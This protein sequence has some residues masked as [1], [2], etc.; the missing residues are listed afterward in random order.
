MTKIPSLKLQGHTT[1]DRCWK[2]QLLLMYFDYVPH[3]I[4]RSA[5]RLRHAA[6]HR[7]SS[8]RGAEALAADGPAE[9]PAYREKELI[10]PNFIVLR[11][12]SCFQTL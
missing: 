12:I 3:T 4:C 9:T 5:W 7:P 10:F 2:F 1:E 8:S 6:L 11:L